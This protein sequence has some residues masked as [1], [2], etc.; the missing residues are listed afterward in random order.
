MRWSLVAAWILTGLSIYTALQVFGSARSL[1]KRP[2]AID[3][4]ILT[5]RYGILSETKIPLSEVL[6]IE[7]TKQEFEKGDLRRTLSP[8]GEMEGVNLIITTRN[9]H[10]ILGLYG[11]KKKF[12]TLG[13]HLDEPDRF[14]KEIESVITER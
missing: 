1:S 11:F 3:N 2:I 8:I 10:T 9:E 5:L 14:H 13:L 12:N 4:E 7:K 6:T